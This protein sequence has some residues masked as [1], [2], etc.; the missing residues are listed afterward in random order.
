MGNVQTLVEM[1]SNQLNC[2]LWF[3]MQT[4][5]GEEIAPNR[6]G[7]QHSFEVVVEVIC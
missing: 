1:G 4:R 2:G 7:V 5:P 6:S 3:G